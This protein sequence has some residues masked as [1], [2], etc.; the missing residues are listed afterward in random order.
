MDI[1]VLL[2]GENLDLDAIVAAEDRART[3]LGRDVNVRVVT[4]AAWER[5][6]DPFLA[7]LH[8]RPLVPVP[9]EGD[10]E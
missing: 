5:A 6:D 10:Q 1:D 4:S 3:A 2:V 8:S 9:L 7:N